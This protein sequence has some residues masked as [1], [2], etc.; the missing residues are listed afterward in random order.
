MVIKS[1]NGEQGLLFPESLSR[2]RSRRQGSARGNGR[3]RRP[4]GGW[5]ARP[6]REVCGGDWLSVSRSA[7]R[8][9]GDPGAGRGALRE[10]LRSLHRP[11]SRCAFA[12]L[13]PPQ[14]P[15]PPPE[16]TEN[17]ADASLSFSFQSPSP[18]S[19]PQPPFP[20]PRMSPPFLDLDP[21]EEFGLNF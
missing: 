4:A 11:V 10:G 3:P 5:Q 13:T 6:H 17:P 20:G 21:S 1:W 18:L 16:P 8:G 19:P 15:S 2:E 9:S 12:H 14:H 7:A